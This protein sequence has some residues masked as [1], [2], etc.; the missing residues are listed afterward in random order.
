MTYTVAT[1]NF[2][3]YGFK[4]T[5]LCDILVHST[6]LNDIMYTHLNGIGIECFKTC[7][8]PSSYL[9]L[10]IVLCKGLL[11]NCCCNIYK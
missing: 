2:V 11:Q 10:D 6:N 1:V 7:S 3:Q 4:L 9:T 5:Y 8:V